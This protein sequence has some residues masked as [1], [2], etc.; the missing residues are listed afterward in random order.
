MRNNEG[1]RKEIEEAIGK[2][3]ELRAIH[4]A[5][6][7]GN[8]SPA[9]PPPQQHS[10][11]DY[12]VFTPSY[13]DESLPGYSNLQYGLMQ[14]NG[15]GII[16]SNYPGETGSSTSAKGRINPYFHNHYDGDQQDTRSVTSSCTNHISTLQA[17]PAATEVLN[18]RRRRNS[19]GDF[20]SISSKL[21]FSDA[22]SIANYS[23][24]KHSNMV[25][26]LTDSHVAFH[27]KPK[28]KKMIFSRIFSRLKK[29]PKGESEGMSQILEDIR[30]ISP[31]TMKKEIAR[32]YKERDAALEEV[33]EM[34]YSLGDLRKKLDNL[35]GYYEELKR[36]LKKG[37]KMVNGDM[38]SMPVGKEVMLEGFL[39]VVSEAR[40]SVKQF[41]KILVEE[42]EETDDLLIDNL[43][44]L[45][46]PYNIS[47]NNS[48]YSKAVLYHLEA[49]V[50]ETIHQDF[51]NCV[52]QRNGSPKIL[53]PHKDRQA[54]FDSFV[55]LRNLSWNEVLRKGTKYHSEDFSRFCDQKMSSIIS[56][57]NWIRPWPEQLLQ[58]FFVAAKCVWLLH[59]L[60]FS[61]Y[62]S[63]T[64]LRVEENRSFDPHYMDDILTDRP[65]AQ[66]GMSRV[67]IMVMPGFYVQD[68]IVR[69]K[70]L[71]RYKHVR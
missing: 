51:E 50:N 47:L 30:V 22:D 38:N 36:G 1:N 44:S 31:E 32:A 40:L 34:K 49:I 56:N 17:S 71:C 25:V 23:S 26:P 15:S 21:G 54:K 55:G 29:K 39:Q 59:L 68:K 64:I 58:S 6:T 61:C 27:S 62:P 69:C 37:G 16:Q 18:S 53:D 11:H 5:L 28:A 65:R 13:E 4:A 48:K 67:K 45:L 63:L 10:A 20:N 60:A 43:N 3:M 41:C 12:P 2:A 35:E 57:L 7:Q 9:H 52:F 8:C 33:A 42:I 24:C 46:Q 19:L 70:V 66:Q 14:D